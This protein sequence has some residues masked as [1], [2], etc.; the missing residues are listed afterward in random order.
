MKVSPLAAWY[1]TRSQKLKWFRF[2]DQVTM[3]SAM[4]HYTQASA[5]ASVMHA[6]VMEYL[7]WRKP[8]EYT[9]SGLFGALVRGLDGRSYKRDYHHRD[10]YYVGH[11]EATKSDADFMYNLLTLPTIKERWNLDELIE[12]FHNGNSAQMQAEN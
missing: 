6:L 9:H 3:V 1:A 2:A 11:L 12:K 4:T 5:R 7:L 10:H 8:H